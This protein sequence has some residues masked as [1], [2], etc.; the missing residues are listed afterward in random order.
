MTLQGFSQNES[1]CAAESCVA[2][3]LAYGNK[4]VPDVDI[5]TWVGPGQCAGLSVCLL[6]RLEVEDG[7]HLA[8]IEDQSAAL[9]S[10]NVHVGWTSRHNEYPLLLQRI[11]Q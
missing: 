9:V 1:Q 4:A 7:E 3:G 2:R 5:M 6:L 10:C 8:G 11:F